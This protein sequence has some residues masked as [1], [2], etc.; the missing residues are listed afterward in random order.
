[1]TITKQEKPRA[2][3]KGSGSLPASLFVPDGEGVGEAFKRT[4]HLGIGAHQDDLE[5]MAFHGIRLCYGDP[6]QW[7]GGVVCTD[8]RGSARTGKYAGYTDDEMGKLRKKEQETAASIGEYSFVAQLDYSS[9]SVGGVGQEFMEKELVSILSATRP[10]VL[11]THNPADKHGTHIGVL[12]AVID[13]IRRLPPGER[14][15]VVY[16]CEV[17]RDLDWMLDE[18]K[19]PL[20]VTDVDG[21]GKR[22]IDVFDSQ[23]SGGKRYSLATFGR[24]RAHATYFQPHET[25]RVGELTFAM[26]LSPLA[27]DDSLDIFQYVR[28]YIERFRRD[29]ETK[30]DRSLR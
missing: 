17:W 7:F 9:D 19:V 6:D 23:I 11:Y 8:G 30:L 1:M 10:G 15:G 14:P 3:Q 21:L 4:T 29:V 20:D 16:G 22:L 18:D 2:V 25:D 24:R 13:A 27:K 26:D 28:G 12:V 5:I